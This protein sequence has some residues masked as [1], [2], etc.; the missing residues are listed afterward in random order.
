MATK[1]TEAGERRAPR[2]RSTPL[3]ASTSA[4]S[5]LVEE[6]A[7]LRR[8]WTA[9]DK[10]AWAKAATIVARH[11][12]DFPRGSLLEEREAVRA[13]LR[14]DSGRDTDAG[15]SFERRFSGSIYRSRVRAACR[16]IDGS[17]SP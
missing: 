4:T 16:I 10:G 6:G 17:N 8:A 14:C 5:R 2:T 12:R 7:L 1:D 3:A 9:L 13:I 15:S 11:E